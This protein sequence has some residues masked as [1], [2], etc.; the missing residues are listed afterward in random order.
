M[1]TVRP[2]TGR[3][4]SAAWPVAGVV[5]GL[6]A[7]LTALSPRYGFHRDELYFLVAG[8]YIPRGDTSTSHR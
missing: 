6:A 3:P 5:V 4:G 1:T 8:F 2:N 7:V